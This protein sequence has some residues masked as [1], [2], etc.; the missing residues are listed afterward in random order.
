MRRD[1]IAV[2]AKVMRTAGSQNIAKIGILFFQSKS[3][4]WAKLAG[5]AIMHERELKVGDSRH[6]TDA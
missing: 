5:A 3:R 6:F 4:G 2:Q 1:Q